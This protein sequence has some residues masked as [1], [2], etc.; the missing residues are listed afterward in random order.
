MANIVAMRRTFHAEARSLF[1][2]HTGDVYMYIDRSEDSVL[3]I[4]HIY[5][6]TPTTSHF[7]AAPIGSELIDT[8]NGWGSRGGG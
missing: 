3:E 2:S 8:A 7:N 4:W 5:A 6:D 1:S